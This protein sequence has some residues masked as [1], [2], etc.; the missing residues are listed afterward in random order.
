[1]AWIPLRTLTAQAAEAGVPASN[2]FV[3]LNDYAEYCEIRFEPLTLAGGPT[4]VTFAL[5]R[6]DDGEVDKVTTI[7][8]A[9]TEVAA[10]TPVIVYLQGMQL[11]ITVESFT[12]GAAQTVAGSVQM[13]EIKL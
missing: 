2:V 1:M 12:G 3:P 13:R 7:T 8:V 6:Y 10:P 9:S 11:W 4:A 5:W